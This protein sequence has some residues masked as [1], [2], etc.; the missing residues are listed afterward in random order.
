MMATPRTPSKGGMLGNTISRAASKFLL[1][2][3]SSVRRA[4]YWK[5]QDERDAAVQ[6]S[7]QASTSGA[8]SVR[9]CTFPL[10]S[11]WPNLLR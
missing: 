2:S 4:S 3:S 7:A 8:P 9:V 1:G 6:A 11:Y 10:L 5:N